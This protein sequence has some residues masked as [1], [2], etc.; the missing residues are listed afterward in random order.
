VRSTYGTFLSYAESVFDFLASVSA[1]T[2]LDSLTIRWSSVSN[3]NFS[4]GVCGTRARST[5]AHTCAGGGGSLAPGG[6]GNDSR[7][8]GD[9]GLRHVRWRRVHDKAHNTRIKLFV[10]E[11][12]DSLVLSNTPQG[13]PVASSS[14]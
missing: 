6:F 12:T 8:L 3:S 11:W 13:S 9:F 1:K 10:S 14:L 4:L 7:N 2:R 5:S